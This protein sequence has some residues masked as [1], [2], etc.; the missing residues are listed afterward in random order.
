MKLKNEPSKTYAYS[1]LGAGLLGYTLG[2]S[3]KSTFQ[4]LLKEKVYDKYNMSSS[5]TTSQN[6][7]NRLIKGLDKKGNSV[8][9]WDFDVLF[10]AGGI[11]STS[12]DLV[13]FA[14]AQFDVENKELELTRIPTFEINESLRIGL[15]WHILKSKNGKELIWHNGR[16]GGYSSSMTLDIESKTAVIILSNVA[17]VNKTIDDLAIELINGTEK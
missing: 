6:L 4:Q 17:E 8:S 5:F 14:N 11:L 10:G 7:D 9:N 13:K 15:G 12:E 2:I 3:Q 16:T 1:N